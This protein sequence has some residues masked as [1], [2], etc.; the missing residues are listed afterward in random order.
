MFP[1]EKVSRVPWVQVHGLEAIVGLQDGAGPFPDT[2]HGGLAAELGAVVGDGHGV[3]VFEADVQALEV[4]DVEGV[5]IC[6]SSFGAGR[7]V[8]G[9]VGWW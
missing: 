7:S 8:K 2:T 6:W 9:K 5:G 3:P 1:V 4:G